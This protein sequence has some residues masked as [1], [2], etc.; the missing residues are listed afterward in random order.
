MKLSAFAVEANASDSTATA[1]TSNPRALARCALIPLMEPPVDFGPR[2][3]RP[4]ADLRARLLAL[5]RRG[6]ARP[7]ADAC[8]AAIGDRLQRLVEDRHR[9]GDLVLGDGQRRRHAQAAGLAAGASGPGRGEPAAPALVREGQ[10]EGV[11]RLARAA[12]L[13]EPRARTPDAGHRP[14]S[15][16]ATAR[17][18][19][20]PR[21]S[22]Q[23]WNGAAGSCPMPAGSKQTRFPATAR[24]TLTSRQTPGGSSGRCG[25]REP[26]IGGRSIL[27]VAGAVPTRTARR[28][29]LRGPGM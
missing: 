1:P 21:S 28:L 3:E 7:G 8:R 23:R 22:P 9:E 12:I 14:T 13:H 18:T 27:T 5:A 17:S 16:A 29:P 15:S 26:A 2:A 25:G 4:A 11:G 24:T 6:A 19:S 10:A 20:R